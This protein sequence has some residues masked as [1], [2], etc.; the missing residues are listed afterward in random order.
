MLAIIEY[1]K[2]Y[3]VTIVKLVK[4]KITDEC[5]I[6]LIPYFNNVVMLNVSRNELTEKSI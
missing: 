4:N 1:V 2:D 3:P 6:K 5:L